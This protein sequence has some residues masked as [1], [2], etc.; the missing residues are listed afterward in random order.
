MSLISYFPL[1]ISSV[2]SVMSGEISYPG[3]LLKLLFYYPLDTFG[4]INKLNT[5]IKY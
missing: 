5:E 4:N 2:S 1:V 3:L